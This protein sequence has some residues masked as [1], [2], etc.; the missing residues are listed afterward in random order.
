MARPARKHSGNGGGRKDYRLSVV[1]LALLLS[2]AAGIGYFADDLPLS[3]E[4]L[5]PVLAM[6][7]GSG[8]NVKGNV[9]IETGERIYHVPGQKYYR[10]TVISPRYGERWF[11][12]EREAVAA[13]WRKS[14]I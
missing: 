5:A 14:G 2:G 13:G 10:Q 1:P 8:C 9:S 7:P 12:S 4:V 3:R 11:C 6:V